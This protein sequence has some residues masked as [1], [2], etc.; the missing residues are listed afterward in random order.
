MSVSRLVA[1]APRKPALAI[2]DQ[3]PLDTKN[4][5]PMPEGVESF[6]M[7]SVSPAK[8]TRG[9]SQIGPNGQVKDKIDEA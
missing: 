1:P 8:A 5:I 3:P 4:L 2:F 9:V 7:L 6:V